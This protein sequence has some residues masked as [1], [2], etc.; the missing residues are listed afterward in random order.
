LPESR[1]GSFAHVLRPNIEEETMCKLETVIVGMI[2]S[3]LSVLSTSVSAQYVIEQVEYELPLS[4]ELLPP[5]AEFD[6]FSEE[7][8]S[9]LILPDTKLAQI[10]R[11]ERVRSTI[12]VA[13]DNVAVESEADGEHVTVILKSAEDMMYYVLW[14]QKKVYEMS[15]ADMDEMQK[16]I[17]AAVEQSLEH[18][19]PEMREQVREAMEAGSVGVES[20][21]RVV[22]TGKTATK[23]GHVCQQYMVQQEQKVTEIWAANDAYGLA[24]KARRMSQKMSE[25]FPSDDDERDEWDLVPGKIPVVVRAVRSNIS[26][27][28]IMSVTALTSIKKTTPPAEKFMP[29][30]KEAGFTRSPMKEMMQQ[31]MPE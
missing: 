12:Y 6:S 29:P 14:A 9:F 17:S 18:L 4:Y 1:A 8:R 16:Q 21:P 7:A 31:M 11:Q 2:V 28:P 23:Y 10:E 13:G 5:D 15:R 30:G 3:W 19:P 20:Q 25:M 26:G 27:E 22:A 24:E